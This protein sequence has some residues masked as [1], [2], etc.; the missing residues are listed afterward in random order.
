MVFVLSLRCPRRCPSPL[1]IGAKG[2]RPR[3]RQHSY[4]AACDR[5]G[6]LGVRPDPELEGGSARTTP[7]AATDFLCA[8]GCDKGIREADRA[9]PPVDAPSSRSR[10]ALGLV[11]GPTGFGLKV[12]FLPFSFIFSI[13]LLL[14]LNF[15]I[16]I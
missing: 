14:Y 3:N 13:L 11:N 8:G 15:F 2:K 12:F 4:V 5:W 6:L 10:L 1:L 7:P 9:D 16:Q